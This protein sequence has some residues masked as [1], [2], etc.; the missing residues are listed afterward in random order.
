MHVTRISRVEDQVVARKIAGETLVV[1]IRGQLADMR[2]IFVLDAVAEHVWDR[3]DG[4]TGLDE[5][6]DSI[7][8][9]FEVGQVQAEQDLHEF[10]GELVEAGLAV[11]KT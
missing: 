8:A 9:R 7:V 3:L 2:Q 11:E 6:R 10:V 5:I 4:E 1:P